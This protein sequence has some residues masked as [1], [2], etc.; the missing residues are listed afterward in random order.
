MKISEKI[1]EK[2]TPKYLLDALRFKKN[3]KAFTNMRLKKLFCFL[4]LKCA[5]SAIPM[6]FQIKKILMKFK[7]KFFI[8]T[9]KD[10]VVFLHFSLLKIL[11]RKELNYSQRKIKF[12]LHDSRMLKYVSEMFERCASRMPMKLFSP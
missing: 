9:V 7:F 6:N 12:Y 10:F 2:T 11:K 8:F 3:L 4:H 5:N 1:C